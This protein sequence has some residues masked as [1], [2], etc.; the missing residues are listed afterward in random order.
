MQH[1]LSKDSILE[2]YLD[3]VENYSTYVREHAQGKDPKSFQ[4]I[5]MSEGLNDSEIFEITIGPYL[6][7]SFV[8]FL[9]HIA[10]GILY[11]IF[12]ALVGPIYDDYL[13]L[14]FSIQYVSAVV[15]LWIVLTYFYQKYKIQRLYEKAAIIYFD[16]GINQ[17]FRQLH[18]CRKELKAKDFKLLLDEK[19]KDEWKLD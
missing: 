4:R 1:N 19:I 16:K 7:I 18:V 15:I 9:G 2:R 14:F 6:L 8:I 13:E 5:V 17:A 10:L 3:E 12:S 11:F